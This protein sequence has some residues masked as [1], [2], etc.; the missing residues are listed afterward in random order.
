MLNTVDGA[1]SIGRDLSPEAAT[2]ANLLELGIRYCTG[3]EVQM[4]LVQAHKWLN[5]AA[6]KGSLEAKEYRCEISREMSVADI[7]EAQRQ[8]R[9]WLTLH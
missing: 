1:I 8:A 3:Q 7:A 6:L 5:L 4:N 9:A 2:A